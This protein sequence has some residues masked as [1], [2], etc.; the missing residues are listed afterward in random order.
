MSLEDYYNKLM[1]LFDELLRLK[2]LHHCTCDE[3]YRTLTQ[4]ESS[5]GI[6]QGKVAQEEVHIFAA[7]PQGRSTTPYDRIDKSKLYSSHCRTPRHD[8]FTCF[9]L[10]GYPEWWAERSRRGQGSS[11]RTGAVARPAASS[12]TGISHARGGIVVAHA[13]VGLVHQCK[14]ST[15]DV[16]QQLEPE[17]VTAL[18]SLLNPSS[19]DTITGNLN[20][21][22]QGIHSISSWIIDTG[23]SH[24][25]TGN[26][27]CLTHITNIFECSI[28]LPNGTIAIAIEVGHISLH[29]GLIL[30]RV[31]YV[32]HLNCSLLSVSQLTDDINCCVRFTNSLCA[33][34]D[35]RTGTLIGAGECKEGL[36]YFWE[37]SMVCVVTIP[38]SSSFELW[39]R[40]LGHP[41]DR[42]LK[43]VP[44]IKATVV[45][46]SKFA[47]RSRKCI[48]VG[49]LN[50]KKGWKVYDLASGEFFV[51]RDVTFHEGEFPFDVASGSASSISEQPVSVFFDEDDE[52]PVSVF[53]DEDDE[54]RLLQGADVVHEEADVVAPLATSIASPST[55]TLGRGLSTKHPSFLLQNYVTNTVRKLSTSPSSSPSSGS[56]GTR[57]PLA[58]YVNCDKFALGHRMFLAAVF[59]GVEPRSYSEAVKD[60]GWRD[61][62]NKELVALEQNKTCELVSLPPGKKAFGCK[63]VYKIKYHSDGSLER[64]K[65]HL[66]IFGNHQ[67][68]GL[69]Y[70]ETFAPVA[71]MVTVRAFLAVALARNWELHQMDVHN[72]FLLLEN[73]STFS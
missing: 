61:A 11:S 52:P 40:R 50:G 7:V 16:G 6:A 46:G 39:H 29:G 33:I 20:G 64:L 13:V 55:K 70:H 49:Y 5:R 34:Q 12:S 45:T 41:S 24:H 37:I 57:Y 59:P 51:S 14:A 69:D 2:P 27:D 73:Y 35:Q 8:L 36:Y 9:K 22:D 66:L 21:S 53:F 38:R 58:H 68:E 10:H 44:E 31:L 65:A 43:L 48:F 15:S 23:A 4:D 56:S 63:W 28:G 71:K 3:A 19:H 25:V 30:T 18:L 54:T 62:M 1:G 72:A 67:V 47:P 60:V 17:Q 42:V 26:Y 32:R